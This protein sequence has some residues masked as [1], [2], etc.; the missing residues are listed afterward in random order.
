MFTQLEFESPKFLTNF[1]THLFDSVP[2]GSMLIA[3]D[4]GKSDQILYSQLAFSMA[5]LEPV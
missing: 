3:F 5:Q 4:V 2:F 1:I